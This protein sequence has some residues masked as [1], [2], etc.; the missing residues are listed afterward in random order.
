MAVKKY[1]NFCNLFIG[2]YCI[3]LFLKAREASSLTGILLL[4][5]VI[6]SCGYF[7]YV[8]F[9][10]KQPLMLKWLSILFYMFTFYGFI[11]IL[12]DQYITD[13]FGIEIHSTDYIKK[14]GAS[15]LP[16]YPMFVFARR[17]EL[18]PNIIYS[19]IPIFIL[20]TI[21]SFFQFYNLLLDKAIMAGSSAVEFTNNTGYVF[22]TLLPLLFLRPKKAILQYVG[23]GICVIF[24][25]AGVKRG[26]ILIGAL[27]I[28][29]F[30]LSTIRLTN[31]RKRFRI[32]V[33]LM[34]AVIVAG[35]Y[36]ADFISTSDYFSYRLYN[37]LE[38]NMSGRDEIYGGIWNVYINSGVFPLL[39]GNGADSSIRFTGLLAHNDWLEI[40]INQG[41]LGIIIFICYNAALFK[42]WRKYRKNPDIGLCLSGLFIVLS[43]K[44]FFSMS[45]TE[46]SLYICIAFGYC[47]SYISKGQRKKS[48]VARA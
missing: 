37:T 35:Y 28:I 3:Y 33:T 45:Y 17:G 7:T 14:I 42:T 25:V 43:L 38:G 9:R 12:F 27:S 16:V 44:T 2:L 11:H 10:I 5:I 46:Y 18:R 15:L 32:I 31:K 48:N 39:F 20:V 4:S 19:W 8:Q 13:S 24:I 40:L 36:I 26:A 34:I 21:Y 22:V 23:I 41:V 1:M 6:I 47:A 30:V 29:Y